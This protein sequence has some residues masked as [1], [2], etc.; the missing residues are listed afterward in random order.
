MIIILFLFNLLFQLCTC[1]NWNELEGKRPILQLD[2]PH[3]TFSLYERIRIVI[4]LRQG[5]FPITFKWSFNN[6]PLPHGVKG[7]NQ[8]LLIP[9]FL[10]S[11]KGVYSLRAVNKYGWYQLHIRLSTYSAQLDL[12]NVGNSDISLK[13][14]PKIIFVKTVYRTDVGQSIRLI[15]TVLYAPSGTKY[16]WKF[17]SSNRLPNGVRVFKEKISIEYVQPYHSGIYELTISNQ[18]GSTSA[19]IV[20]VVNKPLYNVIDDISIISNQP[21][22][23][24][25]QKRHY[26][27]SVG[28]SLTISIR[29]VSGA[30]P[31]FYKWSFFSQKTALPQNVKGYGL[32]F[33]I[34]NATKSMNGLYNLW[35]KNAYGRMKI[36][37]RID[38][39]NPPTKRP[40]IKMRK[41]FYSLTEGQSLV[42][43]PMI[44]NK[45]IFDYCYWLFNGRNMLPKGI[46]VKHEI[47][48]I[49]GMKKS[50]SGTYSFIAR[51]AYGSSSVNIRIIMNI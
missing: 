32:T 29:K 6:G 11:M 47:L 50:Y 35:T 42:I 43:R 39:Y 7:N 19:T 5:D 9:K 45:N 48:F 12:N 16:L 10:N 26:S 18:Y 17:D 30:E 41:K 33:Q 31:L 49:L 37:F 51:N 25:L 2:N 13:K 4:K 38:V 28:E 21:P 27:I 3:L 34:T 23:L 15:P 20:L 1:I 14:K 40:I 24:Y 36:M 46:I 22:K 8:I 44:E